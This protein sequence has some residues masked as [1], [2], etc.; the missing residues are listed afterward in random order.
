M[1]WSNGKRHREAIL[2]VAL[3]QLK[4]A[5]AHASRCHLDQNLVRAEVGHGYLLELQRLV[6][7]VHPCR[8]HLHD[9]PLSERGDARGHRARACCDTATFVWYRV[10]PYC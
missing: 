10:S 5:A 9:R 7:S 6:V 3:D 8:S 1:S 4:I 2:K